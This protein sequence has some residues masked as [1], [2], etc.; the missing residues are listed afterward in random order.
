MIDRSFLESLEYSISQVQA[1]SPNKE[2]RGYQCDGI[3]VEDLERIEEHTSQVLQSSS[4]KAIAIIP[5]GQYKESDYRF[6]M[7]I[8]FGEQA[9]E[10]LSQGLDLTNAIPDENTLEWISLDLAANTITVQLK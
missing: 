3:M 10:K 8:L 2:E 5:R 7:N 9:T 1:N 4:L 6:H